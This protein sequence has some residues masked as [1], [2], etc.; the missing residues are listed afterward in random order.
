MLPRGTMRDIVTSR[1]P[2]WDDTRLW[3]LARPLSGFAETFSLV[4]RRGRARRRQ[5]PAPSPTRGR[6]GRAVRRRRDRCSP[7]GRRH[8]TALGPGGY[9][10]LPP[11]RAGRC[12]TGRGRR[13]PSTGSARPTSAVDGVDVP[14]VVRDPRG[15]RRRSEPMP[16]THGAWG[17]QRFVDP[18]DVRHDMHVN[19]VSF[20]PGGAIPFP[21]THVMEHGLYVLEGK[22]VYLLNQDWVE[23]QA[24]DFMWLRAFCPQACYAGGPGPVPLPALQGRQPA[25]GPA[26][27]RI[28][29]R[30]DPGHVAWAVAGRR[31]AWTTGGPR[32]RTMHPRGGRVPDPQVTVNGRSRPLAGVPAHTN[33]LDFLRG[34]GPDRRQGGLRRGGVRRLRRPG[35][36]PAATG[37]GP[38]AGGPR[39]TPAWCPAAAL[40]GQEVVTAEGLGTPERPAPGAGRARRARRVAVRLLHAGLRLLDGRR[41]LPPRPRPRAASGP[42][43]FDLHAL[44]GNLCRCTGYRPIRDAAEALGRPPD[45]DALA[46]APGRGRHR[47]RP[48][49]R[50]DG[51]ARPADLAEALARCCASTPDA[52]VVAGATDLGVEV[53]LRGRRPAYVVAIDRLPELR[54]VS[55]GDRRHRDR[56]RCRAHPQR[57]RGGARRGRAAARRGLAAVRLAA[58]PQRRDDRRQPRHRVPDRRPAAR[59]CSPSTRRVVLASV[60]GRPRGAAGGLLHRLPRRP[61]CAPA[62]WSARSASRGRSPALTAFHKVAKRRYDDISSVA[63]AFA[64]DVVDGTVVRARI[65]LGGVAATPVRARGDRGRPRGPAVDE[66]HRRGGRGGDARRG[67]ADRR[68]ARQRGLPLGRCSATRCA[69]CGPRVGREGRDERLRRP[70]ASSARPHESAALH[71]TGHALYTDDLVHRTRDVLHAHPV[72]RRT[73]TPG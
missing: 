25:P 31:S 49:T 23:V 39:S 68:P 38:A 64:L 6:G 32:P 15:R 13:R 70:A 9:A 5:R 16:D 36:R 56:D 44:S 26:P 24:G 55:T 53:N 42:N 3:V 18:D 59:R 41:V 37:P 28:A 66:R 29:P 1:L 21:E 45:G 72:R 12:A 40:D 61:C 50:L 51:F 48:P 67:H 43:G 20:E 8:A 7:R 22:A 57:G 33:A 17:T 10:Y 65:G 54:E 62:S 63:V 27:R 60:D 47:R 58:D 11:E 19:I 69:G 14:D 2:F 34:L 71:V 4:R 30:C 73:P 52:T 46:P 35:L